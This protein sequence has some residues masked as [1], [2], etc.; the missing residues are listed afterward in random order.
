[1]RLFFRFGMSFSVGF[2]IGV[3]RWVVVR[4]SEGFVG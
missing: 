1:M 2:N 3:G 4:F